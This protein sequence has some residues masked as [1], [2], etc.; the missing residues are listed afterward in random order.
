[1]LCNVVHCLNQ[2]LVLFNFTWNYLLPSAVFGY[3]YCRILSTVKRQVKVN[4]I[5]V[6]QPCSHSANSFNAGGRMPSLQN[7]REYSS[8]RQD[9]A[10]TTA[11]PVTRT[12]RHL[13]VLLT[14]IT[15]TACFII[16]WMPINF[17]ALFT[18][19]EVSY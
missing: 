9:V 19:F 3:C 16:L 11:P 2:G 6:Q 4:H 8:H 17:T 10:M 1:M 14:M 18:Y 12:D 5:T 13:N 15:V 7:G